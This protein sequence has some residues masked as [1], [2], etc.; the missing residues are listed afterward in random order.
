MIDRMRKDFTV[1]LGIDIS[2]HG[3]KPGANARKKELAGRLRELWPE[4]TFHL[5]EG[6]GKSAEGTFRQGL[7]CKALSLAQASVLR[8]Y[9]R[10][11]RKWSARNEA[12]DPVRANSQLHNPLPHY[13][14]GFL[15]FVSE[16]SR[17]GFD[18][19]QVEMYE[20]LFLGHILPRNASRVFVHHE[21]RFVRHADELSLFKD[22]DLNDTLAFEEAKSME[23]GALRTY[24]RIVTLSEVDRDVLS[25]Y[26]PAQMITA[27]PPCLAGTRETEPAF[28]ACG[29]YAFT[30]SGEHYPNMDA[31]LW[32]TREILPFLR[33][34]GI[35]CR[36]HVAGKWRAK[37]QKAVARDNPEICFAGYVDDLRSFLNGKV[38]IVPLRIG[39]GIRVKILDAVQ[40]LSPF[41]TTAKGV[42]GLPFRHGRECL[43]ADGGRD[44][45]EA[46][47]EMS[48]SPQLQ[49]RLAAQAL[50]RLRAELD[51][52]RLYETRK[53]IYL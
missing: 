33:A 52:S 4:V 22:R 25:A 11:Y 29:E 3:L 8:K 27:S 40:S 26:I 45:A 28:R 53:Q 43:V 48:R 31:L 35:G 12:G 14:P 10:A 44:F 36:I 38:S 19:I 46:M 15:R 21:L 37:D 1:S 32:L 23:I 39:S 42:E 50:R 24:D 6:Q 18:V 5:Y 49:Q 34:K 16:I 30:G 13:D 41:V 20:Y 2:H 47:A 9:R 7:Y 51:P 17:K